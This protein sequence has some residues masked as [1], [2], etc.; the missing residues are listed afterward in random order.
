M[1]S[2]LLVAKYIIKYCNE[3]NYSVSNLKLQKLLYFVQA[4]F[5]VEPGFKKKAFSDRIEAWGFG[6]VVPGVYFTFRRFGATNIPFERS[7]ITED[8]D[9]HWG[10][11]R[12]EY[13]DDTI[14]DSDKEG[15]NEVIELFKEDSAIAM[16]YLTHTQEPWK[17]AYDP[18]NPRKNNEITPESI[19]EFFDNDEEQV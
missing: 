18:E 11:K 14:S 8:P 12:E 6:P 4:Y 13:K 10:V 15:I 9:S 1:Y 19:I 7:Y 5:L 16:M 17:K 2:V 3:K